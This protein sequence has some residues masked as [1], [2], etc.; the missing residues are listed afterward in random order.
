MNRQAID[1]SMCRGMR[2]LTLIELL[3]AMLIG[4]ILLSGLVQIAASAR[5]SFLQQEAVAEVQESG[6]FVL[7]TLGN[8]LRQTV[9]SPR[10]WVAPVAVVGLTADTADAVSVHGDRLA[11]R[12]WSERNCFGNPNPVLDADGQPEF[13]LKESTLELNASS[14][15]AHTCRYGP[16]AA[17]MVN[18]IVRQGLVQNIEAF[19]VLYAEDTDSDGAADRWVRGGGWADARQVLGVHIAVLIRS[20]LSVSE[21]ASR[22]FN[23]LDHVM[24]SPADGRLRRMVSYAQLLQAG[25]S[26]S[27]SIAGIDATSEGPPVVGGLL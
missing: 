16:T 1:P 26:A 22:V 6:R 23:V 19:Q 10:P 25:T 12:T 24:I 3:L 2:G 20:K 8:I 11:I 17:T 21:P 14:N 4:I 9:F 13:Y 27:A 15:L 5:G 18:Q 7:D